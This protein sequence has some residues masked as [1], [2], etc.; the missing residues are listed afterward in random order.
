MYS[1]PDLCYFFFPEL[2]F[3]PQEESRKPL[4]QQS[5]TVHTLSSLTSSFFSLFSPTYFE[6]KPHWIHCFR[7]A[8]WSF[9][10]L[11]ALAIFSVWNIVY[12][13][14]LVRFC[15]SNKW[16][17]AF[18]CFKTLEIYIFTPATW[19]GEAHLIIGSLTPRVVETSSQSVLPWL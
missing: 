4:T 7:N 2:F 10:G 1:C 19:I 11:S 16:S 5:K 8:Q 3:L 18:Q 14:E 6:L 12:Q 9:R 17:L 13:S 15:C